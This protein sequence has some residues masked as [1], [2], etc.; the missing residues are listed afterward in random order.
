MSRLRAFL[1]PAFD[2]VAYQLPHQRQLAELTLDDGVTLDKL[3][4]A[5]HAGAI[6]F[7]AAEVQP[8]AASQEEP[9]E[10]VLRAGGRPRGE[11]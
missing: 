2:S 5:A 9:A 7:I 4:L 1:K 11:M 3:L 10:H 6:D 8:A